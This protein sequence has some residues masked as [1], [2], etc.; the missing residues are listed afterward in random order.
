MI[1]R[2][3]LPLLV[4]LGLSVSAQPAD[5]GRALLD[6]GI[7]HEAAGRIYDAGRDYAAARDAATRA[8]DRAVLA[9]ALVHLAYVQYY[10]GEMNE[11]LVNLQRAYELESASSDPKTR[12][13]AL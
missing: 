3:F 6:R 12:R 4:C 8:G 1:P 11:S 10:R 2:R 9:D 5:G 7:A 13:A